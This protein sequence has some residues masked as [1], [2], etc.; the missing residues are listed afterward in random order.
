MEIKRSVAIDTVPLP[1]KTAGKTIR[2]TVPASV[3]YNLGKMQ[4]A[5]ELVLKRL[6]CDGCHSGFDIR[7]DVATR[8]QVDEKLQLHEVVAGI[9]VTDG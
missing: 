1:E 6:G 7:F 3:A 4:K 2:V 9:V 8:F 5:T